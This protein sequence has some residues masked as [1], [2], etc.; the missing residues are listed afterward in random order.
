M[1]LEAAEFAF[2]KSTQVI[3]KVLVWGS[4]LENFMVFSVCLMTFS[5][6]ES[7]NQVFAL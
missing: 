2:Q 3:M 5:G 1:L 4:H 7:G 6:K